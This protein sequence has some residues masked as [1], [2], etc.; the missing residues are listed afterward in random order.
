MFDVLLESRHVRPP[1]PIVATV[2]SAAFHVALVLVGIGGTVVATSQEMNPLWDKIAQFLAPPNKSGGASAE[3]L[4]FVALDA[5]GSP[6]G[7][8]DG[9]PVEVKENETLGEAVRPQQVAPAV[10]LNDLAKLQIAA[11]AVGAFTV[12]DVDSAAERDPMSAAPAYPPIMLERQIEGAATM[13]FVVDSTGLI[14]LKSIAVQ[15]FTHPEFVKAV[16]EVMPRMHFRPA[17]MGTKAVRQLV[18]Q[19]FKFQIKAPAPTSTLKAI[20]P[21]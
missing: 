8:R 17:L 12:I 11:H 5:V 20:R 14:D 16:Q 10:E 21:E 13:R 18:E 7:D 15:R 4:S 19:E 6:R 9:A 2:L 3:K 1:R